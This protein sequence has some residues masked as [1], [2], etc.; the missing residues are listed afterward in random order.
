V[1]PIRRRSRQS[2]S[3]RRSRCMAREGE[4]LPACELSGSRSWLWRNESGQSAYRCRAHSK[5]LDSAECGD[6]HASPIDRACGPPSPPPMIQSGQAAPISIANSPV[7]F[8]CKATQG[9]RSFRAWVVP[10]NAMAR[11]SSAG[12]VDRSGIL[13]SLNTQKP[14][15][16]FSAGHPSSGTP[17]RSK[18]RLVDV[19]RGSEG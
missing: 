3:I 6:T 18:P 5:R 13:S 19:A 14:W 2:E 11:R 16:F 8:R 10:Q 12:R 1:P 17:P 7:S 9:H 15:L 4:P